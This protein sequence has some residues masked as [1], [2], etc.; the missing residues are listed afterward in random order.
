MLCMCNTN[1]WIKILSKASNSKEPLQDTEYKTQKNYFIKQNWYHVIMSNSGLQR[2]GWAK[3]VII[4][5][6]SPKS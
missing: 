1:S 4:H 6:I 3:G 5:N 2:Y